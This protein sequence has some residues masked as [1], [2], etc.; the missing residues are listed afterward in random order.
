VIRRALFSGKCM[1]SS[2][3]TCLFAQPRCCAGIPSG[4]TSSVSAVEVSWSRHLRISLTCDPG[5]FSAHDGGNYAPRPLIET[6]APRPVFFPARG[7]PKKQPPIHVATPDG[8]INFYFRRWLSAGYFVFSP[9][10]DNPILS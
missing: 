6:D 3:R 4:V 8:Y 5:I 10:R 2:A 7:T 9:L 1:L